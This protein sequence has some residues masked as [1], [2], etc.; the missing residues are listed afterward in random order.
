VKAIVVQYKNLYNGSINYRTSQITVI[1]FKGKGFIQTMTIV[2]RNHKVYFA[3]V[4]LLALWVSIWGIFV[5]EHVDKAIPW[6]APPLHARFIGAIYLSGV[7]IMVG[8]MM[9][10]HYTEVR[11]AIVIVTVWTGMLFVISLFHL[12]EFD[13]SR[14][15]V[16][17]WFGAY[18]LYPLIGFWLTWSH[19]STQSD[20][21]ASP[22]LPNW[23][24]NYFFVQGVILTVLALALL[25]IP[26]FMVN[27]WP[28]KITRMLAQIYSGPFL[29]YGIGSVLL[30][31]QQTLSEVRIVAMGLFVLALGVLV[32]SSIHRSLFSA[33]NPSTWIWFGGFTLVTIF[34]GVMIRNI[35]AGDSK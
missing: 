5:P 34:I 31:R 35:H 21:S 14:G 15:P 2:T 12:S 9:A 23:I 10:H 8:S 24:R 11:V 30:S 16:W 22:S 27:I 29:A 18:I 17:F 1:P 13:F 7:I 25:F 32:A 4:G 26:E 19:R 6:L 28:W 33:S 3:A 20:S